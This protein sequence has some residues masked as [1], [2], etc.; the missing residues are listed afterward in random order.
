MLNISR[1]AGERIIV[2]ENIIVTVLEISGQ[3]ARIGIEAPREISIYREEIWA[4]VKRENEAAADAAGDALA[5][6]PAEAPAAAAPPSGAQ[7]V[8]PPEE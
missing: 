8:T 2:G 7:A 6:L 1:R 4:D 3:T 5:A